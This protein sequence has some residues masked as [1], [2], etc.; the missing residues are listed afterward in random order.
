MNE[1]AM[2]HLMT[3]TTLAQLLKRSSFI[4]RRAHTYLKALAGLDNGQPKT[5]AEVAQAFGVKKLVVINVVRYAVRQLRTMYHFRN[6]HFRMP[7]G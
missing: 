4:S 3:S 2:V 6:S 5:Y 7:P 1:T